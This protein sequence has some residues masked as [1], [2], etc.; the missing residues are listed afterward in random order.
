M[1]GQVDPYASTGDCPLPRE[2]RSMLKQRSF[3]RVQDGAGGGKEE[4]TELGNLQLNR[5]T[6][7]REP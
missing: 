7:L 2:H 1:H 4:S 5:K 6:E 3:Q